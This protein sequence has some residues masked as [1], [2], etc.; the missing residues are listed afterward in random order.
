MTTSLGQR[1]MVNHLARAHA[2]LG[3]AVA[4]V[5]GGYVFASGW[6][7]W[8]SLFRS[9]PLL[10]IPCTLALFVAPALLYISV[11]QMTETGVRRHLVFSA[12]LST[13]AVGLIA[14]GLRFWLQNM[15]G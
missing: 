10:S 13:A 14:L 7:D 11:R 12:L 15:A 5:L 4:F 1:R 2:L 6:F 9:H 8:A 3:S